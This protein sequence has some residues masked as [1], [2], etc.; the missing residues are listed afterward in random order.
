MGEDYNDYGEFKFLSYYDK[1]E[2]KWI[3]FI[4]KDELDVDCNTI[5]DKYNH[6]STLCYF[7][8][9][10]NNVMLFDYF[11]DLNYDISFNE[12]PWAA[13]LYLNLDLFIQGVNSKKIAWKHWLSSGIK[14]ERTYSLINN[15]SL[16]N[17]RFGNLFFANM[18]LHFMSIKYNLKC[19][20]K[21]EIWFNRLGIYFNKGK[22]IYKKNLLV[23]DKNYM[24]VLKNNLE[25]V[26]IIIKNAWFQSKEFSNMIFNYFNKYNLFEKIKNKNKYK[27]RYD[28]NNDLFIHIRLGDIKNRLDNKIK[29]NYYEK[30]LNNINYNVGYISSDNINDQMCID[31]ITRYKLDVIN[32]DEVET[33]MF[34]STCNNIIL[35]GGSFSWL[36][37]F[38]AFYSK[39]IYYP[40]LENCWYNQDIFSF[41]DWKKIIM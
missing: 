11:K 35:S 37:G 1:D 34:G 21:H 40:K 6:T 4:N 15:T 30:L 31:L 9:K 32:Y 13:Y 22:N 33:I 19:Y 7:D 36:I 14:E 12:F 8:I 5:I 20:Y 29:L 38:L 41:S 25:K 18:F 23:N 10:D 17:G 2:N 26:N 28:R 27:E 39:N 3:K 24:H 16:H